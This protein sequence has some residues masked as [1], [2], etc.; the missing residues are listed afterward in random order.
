MSAQHIEFPELCKQ[1][2]AAHRAGQLAV[3][4]AD[5]LPLT[6]RDRGY[7]SA[8]LL[9]AVKQATEHNCISVA[10]RLEAIAANLRSP[11]AAP[12]NPGS[13]SRCCAATGRSRREDCSRVPGDAG[14]RKAAAMTDL[15]RTLLARRGR[16][17][18][19]A[20]L[21]CLDLDRYLG[22]TSTVTSAELSSLWSCT[23]NSARRRMKALQRHQLLDATTR[24]SPGAHWVIKRLGPVA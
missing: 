8:F 1:A 17:P 13:G 5:E 2:Q 12:A 14:G 24:T 6:E 11:P 23:P 7:L 18:D 22:P 20:L 10:S 4:A 9:E 21:D 15:T 16:V 3:A 19:G